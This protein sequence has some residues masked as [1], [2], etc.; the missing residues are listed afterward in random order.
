MG[1]ESRPSV[2]TLVPPVDIYEN[3]AE[4]LLFVDLPGATPESVHLELVGGSLALSA[5]RAEGP[6]P[7]VAW[8][9]SFVVPPAL[10]SESIAAELRDG[11]LK[12][13]F[14]RAPSPERRVIEVRAA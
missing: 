2:P 3:E 6:L 5:E 11:V 12:V 4:V 8:M 9:R 7:A 13:R 14:P 10:R 1:N